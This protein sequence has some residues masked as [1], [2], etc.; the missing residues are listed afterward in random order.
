MSNFQGSICNS[1][2]VISLLKPELASP[3]VSKVVACVWLCGVRAPKKEDHHM[4]E[5]WRVW[6]SGGG[7]WLCQLFWG[8]GKSSYL[9]EPQFSH[10]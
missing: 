6:E 9:L 3:S 7:L 10:L 5:Q 8:F 2:L 4:E 1:L